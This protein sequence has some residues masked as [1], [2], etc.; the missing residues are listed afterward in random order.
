MKKVVMVLITMLMFFV[1]TS[2]AEEL[3]TTQMTPIVLAAVEAN[4]TALDINTT[5]WAYA[6]NWTEIPEKFNAL[7]VMF[8]ATEPNDPNGETLDPNGCTFNYAVYVADYGCS[9]QIVASGSSTVG[10]MQLS[11]N[12]ITLAELNSGSTDPNSCWVDT[13][14]TV[15]TDWK[16]GVSTQNDGGS[17]GMA[18]LIFDRESGKTVKCI[19]TARSTSYLHV[20][21]IAY[22]Y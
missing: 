9:G 1:S 13:L 3:E 4:D 19:I 11:H 10:G 17:D 16:T 22:G 15:T 7:K 21:C 14:G 8:Y 20:W 12:P 5:S 6:K 18:S 2:Y